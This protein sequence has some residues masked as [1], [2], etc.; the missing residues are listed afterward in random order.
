MYGTKRHVSSVAKRHFLFWH[1]KACLLDTRRHVCLSSKETV[2]RRNRFSVVPRQLCCKISIPFC[3]KFEFRSLFWTWV[4]GF[5]I[6]LI[7]LRFYPPI[8][9]PALKEGA[10]IDKRECLSNYWSFQR[11]ER[12]R[13]PEP[14]LTHRK[15]FL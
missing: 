10:T 4:S 9:L 15:D 2:I 1:K 12:Y 3:S 5:G 11:T 8:N 7:A 13:L 14:S 6:S